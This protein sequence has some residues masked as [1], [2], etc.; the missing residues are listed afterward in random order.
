MNNKP[1]VKPVT[2]CSFS[3]LQGIEANYRNDKFYFYLIHTSVQH[4]VAH[5]PK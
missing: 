5:I 1:N 2:R 4:L 3:T